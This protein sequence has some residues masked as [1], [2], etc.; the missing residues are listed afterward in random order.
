MFLGL[1]Y[2]KD[3]KTELCSMTNDW[4][5]RYLGANWIGNGAATGAAD[6]R[7][8]AGGHRRRRRLAATSTRAS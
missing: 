1:Y 2:P 3:T 4:S 8:P 5:G 7:L 6:R